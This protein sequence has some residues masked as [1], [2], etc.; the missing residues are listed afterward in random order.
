MKTIGIIF[1]MVAVFLMGYYSGK[2]DGL[3]AGARGL[4]ICQM[5]H[6]TGYY[7]YNNELKC[8]F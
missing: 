5:N 8:I 3:Y 1:L 2:G 4:E 7:V 6:A